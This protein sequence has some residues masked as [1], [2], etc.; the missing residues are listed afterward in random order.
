[1]TSMLNRFF[2]TLGLLF[3]AQICAAEQNSDQN[4]KQTA[5]PNAAAVELPAK[6]SFY[7]FVLA[8]QS[9]MAGRGDVTDLDREPHQRVLMWTA[10]G[11]WRPAVAPMHFDKPKIAGVGPG[12]AFGIRLAEASPDITIGLIP[13]AVGGS[14]IECWEPGGFHPSTQT[15][16]Y[17]DAVERIRAAS[18]HGT[19]QG[20]L[21]HQGEGDSSPKRSRQYHEKLLGVLNRL[22]EQ[23]Q[24]DP[25]IL[26]GQLGLF[27]ERPW[28]ESRTRV[29]Q[30]HRA[31]ANELPN[32]A[33]VK[34]DGLLPKSDNTH[35]NRESAIEL[36]HRFYEAY[37]QL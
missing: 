12:R 7:L 1:M 20:I 13:C 16:P 17:D 23:C 27:P 8:G 28:N 9:N 4:S 22:R 29:D 31:V 19:I 21:W 26:I 11:E 14:P 37:L 35:F 33:F 25:V 10:D 34:S 32:A 15:H 24:T 30:A 6:E 3:C 36:G 18:E 5:E 2:V